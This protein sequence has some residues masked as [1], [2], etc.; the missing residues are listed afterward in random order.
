MSTWQT[1]LSALNAFDTML[2][3]HAN[4]LANLNTPGFKGQEARFVDAFYQTLQA[5]AGPSAEQ[6]GRNP[7]QVGMGVDLGSLPLRFTQGAFAA[8][9]GPTDLAILGRGFFVVQQGEKILFTR[10]G[11]F[12]L[13]AQGHLVHAGSGGVLLGW[14]SRRD[15][16]ISPSSPLEPIL[17]PLSQPLAAQATSQVQVGGNLDARAPLGTMATLGFTLWDSQGEAHLLQVRFTKTAPNRWSW[18]A[19]A[20]GMVAGSGEVEFSPEGIWLTGEGLLQLSWSNGSTSPQSVR[21]DLKAM[22]QFAAEESPS[23]LFQDGFPAGH[24]ESLAV[25][26]QGLII[27]GFSNGQSRPLAQVALAD[28]PNPAGLERVGGNAFGASANSGPARYFAPGQG[29]LG[30]LQAGGLEMANTDLAW[31]LTQTLIAQR[32]FQAAARLI[33]AA[34]EL[35]QEALNLRR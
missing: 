21:L 4:N 35:V 29:G 32:G 30:R 11:S 22:T 5:A 28:F 10:D 14:N 19:Q 7:K 2:A 25:N 23:L 13:D 15:G 8:T 27:G 24:W 34:D 1:A 3:V 6:G 20:E 33:V 26:E 18:E 9:G 31:E 12:R 17:L 16:A